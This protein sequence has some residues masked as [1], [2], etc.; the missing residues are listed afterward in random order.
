MFLL[1]MVLFMLL[2]MS[3]L[4]YMLLLLLL[5][6]LQM[7]MMKEH[8]RGPIKC[9]ETI[10]ADVMNL[11]RAK[12]LVFNP[13]FQPVKMG[14]TKRLKE[15]SRG[16]RLPSRCLGSPVVK[17]DKDVLNRLL[18]EVLECVTGG[19]EEDDYAHPDLVIEEYT[20]ATI[21]STY[22]TVDWKYEDNATA[23]YFLYYPAPRV[24]RSLHDRAAGEPQP[25][26]LEEL[27][28]MEGPPPDI[29]K[30][31]SDYYFHHFVGE[32]SEWL[33]VAFILYALFCYHG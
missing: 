30:Q 33:D 4:I 2:L 8:V 14:I 19:W 1:L 11:T 25:P 24:G 31:I 28:S 27:A 5:R 17:T 32:V 13:S 12:E 21:G 6:V 15:D 3:L 9:C 23:N 18:R 16:G 20:K 7:G 29:N 10:A 26:S 22:F